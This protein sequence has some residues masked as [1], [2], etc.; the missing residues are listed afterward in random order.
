MSDATPD[1]PTGLQ[2]IDP[3]IVAVLEYVP[4]PSPHN[5]GRR[6]I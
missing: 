2:P 1:T 3:D 4:G 6:V 5:M